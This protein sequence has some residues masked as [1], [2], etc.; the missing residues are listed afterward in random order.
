MSLK[1]TPSATDDLLDKLTGHQP[2]RQL[3]AMAESADPDPDRLRS[4]DSEAG[5]IQAMQ[6]QRQGIFERLRK[7]TRLN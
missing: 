2:A 4:A 7:L 1:N 5:P 6:K 3:K